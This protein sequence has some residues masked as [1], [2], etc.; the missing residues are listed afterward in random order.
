M[1]SNSDAR[2]ARS[3]LVLLLV[4]IVV[5]GGTVAAIARFMP[6]GSGPTVNVITHTVQRGDFE[7]N[8][9]ERG[10]VESSANVE[11]RCEVKSR[12]SGGSRFW[13]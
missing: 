13:M 10:E 12:N 9:V 4:L 1:Q 7:H 5:C 3:L 6:L 11:V 8:V 2:P